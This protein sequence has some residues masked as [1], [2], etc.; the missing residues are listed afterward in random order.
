MPSPDYRTQPAPPPGYTAPLSQTTQPTYVPQSVA[1]SGPEEL[2]DFDE[3]RP[4]PAGYT[5]VKR[6]RKGLIIGGAITFGVTYSLS[7][8]VAAAGADSNFGGSNPVAALWVP[9]VGPFIQMAKDNDSATASVILAAD[10]L[11][12]A[13]GV[14]MF[15]VGLAAPRTVLVRND[16]VGGMKVQLTPM[17]GRNMNGVGLAGSF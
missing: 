16:L 3:G 10:G 5:P 15:V 13:A 6:K 14:A 11:A 8:L 9:V 12:Q 2:E 17:L 1:L 4:L 7:I